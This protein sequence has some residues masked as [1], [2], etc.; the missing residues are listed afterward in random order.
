[1]SQGLLAATTSQLPSAPGTFVSFDA[2]GACKSAVFPGCTAALAINPVGEILGYS[3]DSNG[4]PH[5]F[6]RGS[7]GTFTSFDVPGAEFSSLVEQFV[8]PAGPSLNVTGDATGGYFDANGLQHGF[9][10]DRHGVITTFDAPGAVNGTIPLSINALG[11]V[12]G[13]F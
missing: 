12:T 1:L 11:E 9:V 13:F 8:G 3:V 6:L 7:N 5:G 4:V 2:P 10:R